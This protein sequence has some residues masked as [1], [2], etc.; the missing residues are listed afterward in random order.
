MAKAAKPAKLESSS[1]RG[2][3]QALSS[4][5]A[6]VCQDCDTEESELECAICL[7]T[8][9]ASVSGE[10]AIKLVRLR[11]CKHAMCA[12]CLHKHVAQI[13]GASIW[14]PCCRGRL[15]IHDVAEASPGVARVF[16]S[17]EA[18]F[19]LVQLQTP[20][21]SRQ[22]RREMLIAQ[23]SFA[24]LAR[25]THM[26]KCPACL[27]PIQK[28]GGCNQMHCRRCNHR[29]DWRKAKTV[30]PCLHAHWNDSPWGYACPG[31][32]P[33]AYLELA[34]AR[35]VLAATASAVA[36][37]VVSLAASVVTGIG[38]ALLTPIVVSLPAAALYHPMHTL[39]E[40]KRIKDI[41]NRYRRKLEAWKRQ[42]ARIHWEIARSYLGMYAK[43]GFGKA[44]L[45]RATRISFPRGV[46]AVLWP[47]CANCFHITLL[48]VAQ[49]RYY[50]H[51]AL[52]KPQWFPPNLGYNH[53]LIPWVNQEGARVTK[54]GDRTAQAPQWHQLKPSP[55]P[56]Q[57][58]W[59][60]RATDPRGHHRTFPRA[61]SASDLRHRR[62]PVLAAAIK[63]LKNAVSILEYD[64]S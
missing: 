30:I 64:S 24:V 6:P 59:T 56:S 55:P 8:T 51:E 45:W 4:A 20:E 18:H 44:D 58:I 42:R 32:H 48:C 14:C 41:D 27:V 36:T 40:K 2:P 35:P 10:E 23:R 63:P 9:V 29:F 19:P 7:Q 33:L 50:F 43:E 62:N 60:P 61:P 21:R 12:P 34:A 46:R 57:P 47:P 5:S 17:D 49:T 22:I 28:D 52:R 39:K 26:K 13:E 53:E 25:K 16:Q 15:H 11:R 37:G 54:R 31:S 3:Y 38:V 1:S